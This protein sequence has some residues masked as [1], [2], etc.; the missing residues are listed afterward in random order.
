MSVE[1]LQAE[2]AQ[3]RDEL[4]AMR[5]LTHSTGPLIHAVSPKVPLRDQVLKLDLSKENKEKEG[6][7]V[8]PTALRLLHTVKTQRAVTNKQFAATKARESLAAS[9][10]VLQMLEERKVFQVCCNTGMFE[11]SIQV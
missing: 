7:A 9:R 8:V 1:E 6:L 10:K 3:L 2:V 4:A 11:I 5:R